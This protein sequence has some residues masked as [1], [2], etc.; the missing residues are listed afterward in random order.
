MCLWGQAGVRDLP[1][2]S[3]AFRNEKNEERRV[4]A[5][6][7]PAITRSIGSAA[8]MLRPPRAPLVD[9]AKDRQTA[10]MSVL[11]SP[12]CRRLEVPSPP[13][14]PGLIWIIGALMREICCSRGAA[15]HLD[16]GSCIDGSTA[17]MRTAAEGR[18]RPNLASNIVLTSSLGYDRLACTGQR[19]RQLPCDRHMD[20]GMILHGATA[21]GDN[22]SPWLRPWQRPPVCPLRVVGRSRPESLMNAVDWLKPGLWQVSQ[23]GDRLSPLFS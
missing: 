23:A 6:T 10:N 12:T 7:R 22:A 21:I 5:A 2:T 17:A 19:G 15:S 1:G 16:F 3:K 11:H 9:F 4:S 14:N 18:E 20:S 13:S 8:G